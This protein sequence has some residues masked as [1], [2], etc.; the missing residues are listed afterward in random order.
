MA[1]ARHKQTKRK[2]KRRMLP[3]NDSDDYTIAE[4]CKKRRVS[5][6][7]FYQML[8]AGTAPRTMKL[9]KHRTIPFEAD[10]EWETRRERE[11]AE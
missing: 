10:I 2:R 5:R 3:R 11:Q 9:N 8:K 4:W 6:G 1:T 7:L